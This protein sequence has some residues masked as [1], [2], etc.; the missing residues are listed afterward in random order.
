MSILI[1]HTAHLC[2]YCFTRMKLLSV[3]AVLLSVLALSFAKNECMLGW[4]RADIYLHSSLSL[5]L[6]CI[7]Y[8]GDDFIAQRDLHLDIGSG[9]EF[10]D[11]VSNQPF[12]YFFWPAVGIAVFCLLCGLIGWCCCC[13]MWCNRPYRKEPKIYTT[14]SNDNYNVHADMI[15]YA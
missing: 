12:I 14:K 3:A 8:E 15:E 13:Y 9:F 10:K 2:H 7:G 4:I 11:L 1:L 6:S 5:S